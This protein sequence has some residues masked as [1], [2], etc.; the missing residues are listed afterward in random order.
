MKIICPICQESLNK[1]AKRYVCKQGH[2]FDI[3]KEGYVNLA[4]QKTSHSGDSDPAV[5]ARHLF[6]NR[7]YY[8]FLRQS[9]NDYVLAYHVHKLLDLACGE[10]YY[11]SYLKAT[12][13]IGIDLSKKALKLA[14]KNDHQSTYVLASIFHAP[15]ADESQDMILTCFAPIADKEI[16]RML[17]K[18]G[19]FLLV[20]PGPKHLIEL[21]EAIYEKPYRNE[22]KAPIIDNLKLIDKKI[23]SDF[24]EM[25]NDDL[26][27]LFMM[28]PY[29]F[30]TSSLDK[31]KLANIEKLAITLEFA[32]SL[33]QKG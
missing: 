7:H 9:L 12:E 11:T 29:F 2:S 19:Y 18:G 27:N 33:F 21:K 4:M 8:H 10:G 15:I 17:K 31:A 30:K 32:I 22:E 23:I 24:V 28:T 20:Q 1:E 13:K 26:Q 25:P 14:A 6:L 16:G 5:I 3:A